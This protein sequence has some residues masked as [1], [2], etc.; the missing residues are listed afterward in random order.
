M[1]EEDKDIQERLQGMRRSQRAGPETRHLEAAELT[2]LVLDQLNK[3]LEALTAELNALR[4]QSEK[5][6]EVQSQHSRALVWW[7]RAL[8]AV[9]LVYVLVAIAGLIW[10]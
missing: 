2:P 10:K 9:T 5:S 6:S 8:V 7:T 4:A 1:S 3:R